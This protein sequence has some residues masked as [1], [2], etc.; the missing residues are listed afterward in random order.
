MKLS[1]HVRSFLLLLL[2]FS[3]LSSY[4]PPPSTVSAFT[5]VLLTRSCLMHRMAYRVA[6][7]PWLQEKAGAA[8]TSRLRNAQHARWNAM[9]ALHALEEAERAR[10]C[11]DMGLAV[12]EAAA[13]VRTAQLRVEEALIE[14]YE[15]LPSSSTEFKGVHL[16]RC[17]QL[18]LVSSN[19]HELPGNI[20]DVVAHA[21]N[22]EQLALHIMGDNEP[23]VHDANVLLTRVLAGRE[24]EGTPVRVELR[25]NYLGQGHV[26]S[27]V[28][29]FL[30][31]V[32]GA[33]SAAAPAP[34]SGAPAGVRGGFLSDHE[35]G[36][37]VTYAHSG[38][39]VA[40]VDVRP[41]GAMNP[42]ICTVNDTTPNGGLLVTTL[43]WLPGDGDR[44]HLAVNGAYTQ[45]FRRVFEQ[46]AGMGRFFS[47]IAC[48]LALSIHPDQD[49]GGAAATPADDLWGDP[50]T[51]DAVTGL[52]T[53]GAFCG[54]CAVTEQVHAPGHVALQQAGTLETVLTAYAVSADDLDNGLLYLGLHPLSATTVESL[55]TDF[56]YNNPVAAGAKA[57]S[58]AVSSSV[59]GFPYLACT[60][61]DVRVG[62]VTS[63]VG[64]GTSFL[65]E[66][67]QHRCPF[68]LRKWSS[69]LALVA[70]GPAGERTSADGA[71]TRQFARNAGHYKEVASTWLGVPGNASN[72]MFVGALHAKYKSL[73]STLQGGG[74]G[75]DEQTRVALSAV[76]FL[77]RQLVAHVMCAPDMVTPNT[78]VQRPLFL[79]FLQ[80]C[81]A[82]KE[83]FCLDQVAILGEL[84]ALFGPRGLTA[85][86]RDVI[87]RTVRRAYV[88]DEAAAACRAAKVHYDAGAAQHGVGAGAAQ[89]VFEELARG[90]VPMDPVSGLYD[91][92]MPV[93]DSLSR[94]SL[95]PS[96][97]D[98]ESLDMALGG[99]PFKAVSAAFSVFVRTFMLTD[100]FSGWWFSRKFPVCNRPFDC[101]PAWL[102][103]RWLEPGADGANG[104]DS[105]VRRRLRELWAG[106]DKTAVSDVEAAA[107]VREAVH[108]R[109][110]RINYSPD[111]VLLASCFG[112]STMRCALCGLQFATG[113]EARTALAAHDKD[114]SAPETK[115]AFSVMRDRVLNHLSQEHGPMNSVASG[116]CGPDTCGA[117]LHRAV[118]EAMLNPANANVGKPGAPLAD[119]DV[120]RI[121][122]D[123]QRGLVEQRQGTEA[124]SPSFTRPTIVAVV[125]QYAA[126]RAAGAREPTLGAGGKLY[127]AFHERMREELAVGLKATGSGSLS[128]SPC[129]GGGGGAGGGA[130][131]AQ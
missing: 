86:E 6:Y 18:W 11:L 33:A 54:P 94:C 116:G 32:G 8:A 61:W 80:Y 35:L 31:V 114:P 58:H 69:V 43:V 30:D 22:N 126:L 37:G 24:F 113:D 125:E 76:A 130:G 14:G 109:V 51:T 36:C 21:H 62:G 104:A 13:Q 83:N 57:E 91:V 111:P 19:C 25:G 42:V 108:E 120:A 75:E 112:P 99:G 96:S 110:P 87:K 67:R 60:G 121:S 123:V 65:D 118:Q 95:A 20:A 56:A 12:E 48:A 77:L 128:A 3:Y 88:L 64:G 131:G 38:I 1:S 107:A 53:E 16:D 73:Q 100:A 34:A 7:G 27:G 59:V 117:A 9:L 68:T 98:W 127:V 84:V 55:R 105:V 89:R 124:L 44:G 115:Q 71:G 46:A 92:H 79:A 102:T 85:A 39:T 119:A 101:K 106:G 29:S 10:P 78:G 72:L 82:G 103:Q 129:P 90:L 47:N 66:S 97:V 5:P 52:R 93:P 2:L 74:A 28:G 81:E 15:L 49:G 70:A 40:H 63:V 17:S 50:L 122:T 41:L 4:P 26:M 23:F 45:L